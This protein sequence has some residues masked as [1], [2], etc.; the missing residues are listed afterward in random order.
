M[1]ANALMRNRC[2]VT[3]NTF[4]TGAGGKT[5]LSPVDIATDV[6]CLLQEGRGTV[7][8][9][10]KGAQLKYDAMI[11]FRTGQDVRADD[12]A[13]EPDII[14]MTKPSGGKFLCMKVGDESGMGN[15]R[16][17]YVRRVPSKTKT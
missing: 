7:S 4:V 11:F 14:T 8:Y 1:S 13:D 15:H 2:T 6:R 12:T 5:T 17:A 16:T 9:G 3:R 10:I